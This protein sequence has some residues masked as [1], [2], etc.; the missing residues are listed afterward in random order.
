M[1]FS[2]AELVCEDWG[3]KYL[4]YFYNMWME[5]ENEDFVHVDG[6]IILCAE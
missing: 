5:N 6:L 3:E 2:V 4:K 1:I